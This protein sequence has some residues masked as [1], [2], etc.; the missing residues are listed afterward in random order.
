MQEQLDALAKAH[1]PLA[2]KEVLG[3]ITDE[4]RTRLDA[5][6]AEIDVVEMA[7]DDKWEKA[8]GVRYP[9]QSYDLWQDASLFIAD[10]LSARAVEPT[11]GNMHEALKGWRVHETL[12]SLSAQSKA[13]ALAIRSLATC[14]RDL[15]RRRARGKRHA[16]RPPTRGYWTRR[17]RCLACRE[18]WQALRS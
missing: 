2:I 7:A 3:T 6:R 17:C 8:H 1:G 10:W 14:L 4:E 16:K 11:D 15:G 12:G 9:V 18:A 13:G 5:V